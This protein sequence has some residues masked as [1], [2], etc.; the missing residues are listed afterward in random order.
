MSGPSNLPS[1]NKSKRKYSRTTKSTAKTGAAAAN[2]QSA[3]KVAT[4]G[5]RKHGKSERTRDNY[6]GHIRRG[7]D[8][9]ANFAKEEQEAEENWQNSEDGS[10]LLSA[11]NENEIPTDVEAQ[12]DQ[13]FHLAFSGTPIR[14]SPTA[15]AMFLA[16]KCFTEERAKSTA[17]AVHSAFLD[18]Y[19]QM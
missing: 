12:M 18:H 13:N 3:F 2:Y 4:E 17:T 15:I 6:G 11:E 1:K 5:K 7:I 16:H 8:F 9:L 10:N 19:A 14:C